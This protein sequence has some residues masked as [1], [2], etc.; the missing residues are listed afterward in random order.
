MP[1]NPAPLV[2][3][4][5]WGVAPW[6]VPGA[7]R[8]MATT[9]ACLRSTPG[10]RFHKL[11]GTGSGQTFT[12][13][14]ADPL[15]WGLLT[16]WDD[17]SAASQFVAGH[18]AT[19]SWQA[20]AREQLVVSLRPVSS[21]GSWAG[22]RP[23]GA[24]A[25]RRVTGPVASLTRARIVPCKT[26]SFW[27]AVPAVSGDLREVAGLRMVLGIGE[28]PVGLQGTFSLWESADALTGFAYRMEAH[29]EAIRRTMLER[30]YS[31][32]LFARF[33]VLGINGTFR[34]AVP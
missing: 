5:L 7:M 20:I 29:R 18:R 9:R 24:P 22:G 13:R 15:H 25:A 16:A 4:H 28:A 8:R 27:R 2:L 17:D 33:E 30:W 21:R 12:V 10:L 26:L 11:L 32:E 31:E 6:H 19:S 1:A 3:L 14:D 34:G 23:F